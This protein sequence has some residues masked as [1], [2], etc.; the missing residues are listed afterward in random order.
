MTAVPHSILVLF[1]HPAY[2]KSRANRH[3][4][5][6]I[7]DIESV[8]FHDLYEA[9][10][11]YHVD[12]RREQQLLVD[13]DIIVF[14]HPLYWYSSPALLKEWMDLVLEH[15]FAYGDTSALRGKRLFT[16]ITTGGGA[17][18]YTKEGFN[19][20]TIHELLAPFRQTAQFCDMEYLPPFVVHGTLQNPDEGRFRQRA[21]DYREALIGLRDATLNLDGID[22]EAYMNDALPEKES[23]S[24]GR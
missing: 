13:H 16:A 11:D 9:Y 12:V 21:E 18:A 5:E 1:A 6:L 2:Q 8:T 14:Q 15:G 10:P 22:T 23:N 4:V 3:L 7:S 20:H 17:D 24:H 19:R